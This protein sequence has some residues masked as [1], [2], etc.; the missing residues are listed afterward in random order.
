MSSKTKGEIRIFF[1]R[2]KKVDKEFIT[3]GLHKSNF[4]SP[5]RRRKT[6]HIRWKSG[7]TQ[8]IK[9]SGTVNKRVTKNTF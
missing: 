8:G 4:S 1:F 9:R 7:S 6:I 2:H 3:R 5:A